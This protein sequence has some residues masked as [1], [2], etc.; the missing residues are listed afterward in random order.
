MFCKFGDKGDAPRYLQYRLHN[1]GFEVGTVDGSYGA[2]TAKA[3]AAAV[4]AH[5]GST[6]DGRTYG[7]AQVIYLD[8]LWAK[9]YA[10]GAAGPRGPVGATG[11]R[12]PAGP[13]GPT[14]PQG[15]AGQDGALSGVLRIE[16][17]TLSVTTEE[18]TG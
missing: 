6:V 13:E 8:V 18:G 9:K 11:E 5:N 17:G 7:P 4:K 14:G 2:N 15:P 10:A 16:G 12:G 1:L 3:L